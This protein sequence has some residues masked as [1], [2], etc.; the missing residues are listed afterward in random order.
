MLSRSPSKATHFPV[1]S[2]ASTLLSMELVSG[3]GSVLA[4]AGAANVVLRSMERLKTSRRAPEA[5]DALLM[6][7]KRG[8]RC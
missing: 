7:L 5:I 1:A 8:E 6:K 2:N 4:I 3:I